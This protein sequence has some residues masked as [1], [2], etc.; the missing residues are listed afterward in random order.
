MSYVGLH[1]ASVPCECGQ[2]ENRVCSWCESHRERGSC[3]TFCSG[4]NQDVACALGPTWEGHGV[5]ASVFRCAGGSLGGSL[6]HTSRWGSAA[7]CRSLRAA[8]SAG[9]CLVREPGRCAPFSPVCES[10]ESEETALFAVVLCCTRCGD[11]RAVW[12]SAGEGDER[13][14]GSRGELLVRR[15]RRGRARGVFQTSTPRQLHRWE[16]SVFFL[17]V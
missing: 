17:V 8:R 16:D 11:G 5:S 10:P 3:S 14:G 1:A 2:R 9:A 12:A 15:R 7:W 6:P 4:T 13:S